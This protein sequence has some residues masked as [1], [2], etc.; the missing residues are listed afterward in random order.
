MDA[1]PVDLDSP[2]A[3]RPFLIRLGAGILI[4]NLFVILMAVVSLRQSWRN[5]QERAIVTGQNLAQVLDRYVA[6]TFSRADVAVWAVKDEVER[7]AANP[8]GGRRDLDAFIRRQHERVPG[9]LALRT[10]DATGMIDHG[11][12][13]GGGTRVS[14][15]DREHFIQLRDIPEAGVVISKPIF[16]RLTGTWVIILA[17]RLERPDHSFAGMVHA[18][19]A[20]DQF[21]QA[22]S[23]LDVGPHGSVALRN[24]ELELIARHPEPVAA[25]TGVGQKVISS[26][27]SAFAQSGRSTGIYRARTP[28]DH[29]QRTFAI[30]RVTGQPFFVLVGLAEQDYLAGWWREAVQELTEVALFT[31]LTLVASW[32]MHRAWRRQQVVHENLRN[33]LT[34]VK[35]LGGMLPICSH[36]KKIRDDKGYWNQI[37]TYL[38]EHTDAEFTHGICPECAKE[39]FPR[40]SGKHPAI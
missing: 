18:V 24:L 5:H 6:D 11:S 12:G 20:L 10:T 40:S 8:K 17:R 14:V 31:C 23:S 39:V 35:T 29:V 9:L 27:F 28:F 2:F 19:I 38:N 21:S 4:L 13:L 25:G 32:L 22:F 7:S 1:H 30:R 16:G 33:L 3:T 26:E 36:C 37:E 34:E 15:A